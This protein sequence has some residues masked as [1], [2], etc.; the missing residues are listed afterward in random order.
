LS[1]DASDS[2]QPGRREFLGMLAGTVLAGAAHAAPSAKTTA[3]LGSF[4]SWGK[5]RG[6]GLE[7]ASV[8]P[9]SGRLTVTG[10]VEGIPDASFL[11]LSPNRR[12][13]YAVNELKPQGTVTALD[14]AAD[15]QKPKVLSRQPSGGGGPTHLSV[16]PSGRYLLTAN[17]TD[18]S[19]AVHPLLPD[20][21]IEALSDLARHKGDTRP[22]RA[23]QVVTDPSGKWVIA[24]DLG[25]DAVFVYGLDLAGGRL[26]LHQTLKLPV[27]T[28][29]RHLA[30][31]PSGRHAYILA[32]LRPEITVAA[33]DAAAGRLTAAQVIGT[34]AG[35][36]PRRNLPAEI[37]IC[38][39][40]RF[41]YASNRGDD[42][43]ALFRTDPGGGELTFA[44]TAPSGGNWPRHFALDPTGRWLYV[45]NQTSNTVSWL[46]RDPDSGVLGPVAGS[47]PVNSVG[48]VLFA[49]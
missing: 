31:H 44:G 37:Q 47:A 43:I 18:G 19:V 30:F 39:D 35:S 14:I 34:V 49:G 12:T 27:G 46:P 3:Y 45:A 20:G 26:T 2:N 9:A 6:R 25:A 48:M 16:H 15:P 1:D 32:E 8:E 38:R 17:Y 33:W 4:S 11:A 21:R 10:L 23:H 22:P 29:P 13:L 28:G 5:P 7:V 40:G 41:V 36:A 24:V 42:S